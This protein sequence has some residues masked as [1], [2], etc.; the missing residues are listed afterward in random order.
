[1]VMAVTYA[2]DVAPKFRP[3][4]V[5]CMARA[6]VRLNEADWM[7]SDAATFGY[8]D[9][10]NARVVF[11]KL[12]AGS[13]PPDGAWPSDWTETYRAWMDDGFQP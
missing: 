12:S 1:M 3:K 13:M 7:C 4:D 11:A 6:L 2:A 10:G 5:A 8:P 9:H